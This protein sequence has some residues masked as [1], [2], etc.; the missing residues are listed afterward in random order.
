M[1]WTSE[2][3][4]VSDNLKTQLAEGDAVLTKCETTQILPGHATDEMAR[5][6][7]I[8]DVRHCK[9]ATSLWLTDDS[10]REGKGA[11]DGDVGATEVQAIVASD[12]EAVVANAS[13]VGATEVTAVVA[14]DGNR[15]S[16]ESMTALTPQQS[17]ASCLT[18]FQ[19][20]HCGVTNPAFMRTQESMLAYRQEALDASDMH[21]LEKKGLAWKRMM[22]CANQLLNYFKV[23]CSELDKHVKLV[24]KSNEK[25]GSL[26]KRVRRDLQRRSKRTL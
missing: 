21:T 10:P 19:G 8:Q 7:Y 16:P 6:T 15:V 3:N 1:T 26:K 17:L 24:E 2:L 25:K 4:T 20:M 11:G 23:C 12:G 22:R 14:N 5:Q 18:D 13:D 9:K